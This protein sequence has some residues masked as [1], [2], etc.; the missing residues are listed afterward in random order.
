M[1]RV[2]TFDLWNT[3]FV[4]KSYSEIRLNSF[5]NFL[6]EEEI[7]IPFKA[8]EDAY[9]S[10][11][12]FHEVTF[13]DINFR[14]IY[15]EERIKNVLNKLELTITEEK[16]DKLRVE[17]ESL[18]I[19]DPPSLKKGVKNTLEELTPDYQLGL[20]SN[21]GVT[22]GPII[23]QVLKKYGILNCFDV[24]IYSDET[25]LFKPHSKMFEIPL[26]K[27][28]CKASNAIHIGDMIETDIK[29]AND[30]NM[31]SIWLNDSNEINL[32]DIKPNYEISQISDAI[33]IIKSIL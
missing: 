17:F 29:G 33:P 7:F 26:N 28:N 8:V 11:F 15:T 9:H 16:V 4:K 27:L 31:I 20:I 14:H 6:K 19:Q 22:P 10:K 32:T 25:G 3:L 24:T 21:T 13:E 12:H 18:M 5:F 23:S 2:I 1:I 30:F